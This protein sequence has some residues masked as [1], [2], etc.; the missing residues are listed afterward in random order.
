MH[1]YIHTCIHAYMDI[2]RHTGAYT[3]T[4]LHMQ[5]HSQTID[6]YTCR[7]KY[8]H[9]PMCTFRHIH[10]Y[11]SLHK[12]TILPSLLPISSCAFWTQKR[13]RWRRNSMY[14]EAPL[15]VRAH[16]NPFRS[17]HINVEAC[18]HRHIE[19]QMY[20]QTHIH[21]DTCTLM[22]TN[23]DRHRQTDIHIL[24][25]TLSNKLLNTYRIMYDINTW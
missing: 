23:T 5:T 8:T 10:I 1:T 17:K 11:T 9:A 21:T 13:K 6:I 18:T 3:Y 14:K 4:H 22:H 16:P 25:E 2:T 15:R 20:T 24:W 19:I 12:Q 7:L